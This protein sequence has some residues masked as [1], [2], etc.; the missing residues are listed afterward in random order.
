MG[1]VLEGRK[2]GE[3]AKGNAVEMTFGSLQIG[4]MRLLGN[5]ALLNQT[6]WE[7]QCFFLL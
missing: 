5:A 2:R 1:R 6:G 3:R 4:Q 7:G